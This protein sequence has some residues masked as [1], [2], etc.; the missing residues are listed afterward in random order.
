M[1][2]G[3]MSEQDYIEGGRRAWLTILQNAIRALGI[4]DVDA[5]KARWVLERQETVAKRREICG[6]YGDD[7][8]PDDLHLADVLEK[9]LYRHLGS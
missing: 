4:N 8:W 5:G 2:G 7:D 1:K 3:K 9:H 6:E